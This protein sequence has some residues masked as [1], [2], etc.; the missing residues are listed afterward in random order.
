[1]QGRIAPPCDLVDDGG[2]HCDGGHD[3][4]DGNDEQNDDNGEQVMMKMMISM[5]SD[6]EGDWNFTCSIEMMRCSL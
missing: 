2:N 5:T 3:D 6:D 4:N 1:M